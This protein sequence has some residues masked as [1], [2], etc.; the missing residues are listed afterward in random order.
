[1]GT[2]IDKDPE[3]IARQKAAASKEKHEMD[4]QERLAKIIERQVEKAKTSG[5][6]DVAP[7]YTELKRDEDGEKVQ[8]SFTK[9]GSSKSVDQPT[10]VDQPKK[11]SNMLKKPDAPKAFKEKSKTKRKSALDEILE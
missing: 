2:Y 1:M 11:L 9:P 7:T 8:L 4:D 6:V 5:T 3:V 10:L